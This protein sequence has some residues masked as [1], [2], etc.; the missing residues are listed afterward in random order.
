[1]NP[2]TV[3]RTHFN[4]LAERHCVKVAESKRYCNQIRVE[5]EAVGFGSLFPTIRELADGV[6]FFDFQDL[7]TL[8]KMN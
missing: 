1:M 5:E 2:S 3:G 4:T 8:Q 6:I 7:V